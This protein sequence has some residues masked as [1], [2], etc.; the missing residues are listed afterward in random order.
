M[1]IIQDNFNTIRNGYGI[2]EAERYFD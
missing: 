2:T 1:D